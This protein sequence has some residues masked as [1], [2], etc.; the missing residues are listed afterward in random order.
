MDRDR[1]D[2]GERF[3]E[4][5][6]AWLGNETAC[7]LKPPFFTTRNV[8]RLR[9]ADP[10]DVKL[11]EQLFA[12]A[13]AL[14][15]I[16]ADEFHDCQQILLDCQLAKHALFLGKIPHAAVPR[17]LEHRPMRD[18]FVVEQHLARIGQH[19]PAC[20]TKA[21]CLAGTVGPQQPDDLAGIDCKIDPV[22]NATATVIFNQTLNR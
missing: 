4:Q 17:S 20:H 19:H 1:V 18:L 5:N 2:A 7:D 21:G 15:A 14:L 12:A 6:N 9:P 8:M 16:H 22:Y 10:R 11:L 3:I 13:A